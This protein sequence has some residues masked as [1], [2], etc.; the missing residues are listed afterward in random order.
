VLADDGELGLLVFERQAA[1]LHDTPEGNDFPTA[2]ELERQLCAA[3]FVVV[4]RVLCGE[5]APA[6]QSWSE[7]ADRVEAA[8]AAAHGTDPRFRAAQDQQKRIADL[9]ADG[10]IGGEL[11]HAAR[12][13]P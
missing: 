7:R 9:L 11:V 12:S 8:I 5:L 10:E 2:A 13:A 6:P 4:D 1:R 3:G